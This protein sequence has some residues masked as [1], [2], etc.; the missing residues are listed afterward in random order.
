MSPIILLLLGFALLFVGGEVLVRAAVSLAFRIKI[1]TL[2]VGMTVVSFVTSAPELFVSLEALIKDSSNI[3][4]GNAIGS[5]IANITLVLGI[6]AVIFRVTISKQTLLLNYPM[7]LIASFALGLVLFFFK[8]IPVAFGFFFIA[9]LIIF[10]WILIVKSRR[11]NLRNYA[12]KQ[13]VIENT[14][15]DSLLKI[16]TFLILGVVSLKYGAD[17]LVD[18]AKDLATNFGVSD[19]IIAVTVLAIG[20]SIPELATSI[21]AAFKKE[22]NLLMGNLIGSNMFNILAVLGI[23]AAFKKIN[24]DDS[25]IFSFD[26]FWMLA[27][28]LALGLLIYIFSKQ[29]ISRKEGVFLILIYLFYMYQTIDKFI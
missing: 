13:I 25:A 15:D 29:K 18:A 24:I 3:A 12:H 27:V 23:T 10:V 28:T 2:V 19:R 26:Y 16:I 22:D 5:N 8:S 14:S 4:L 17:F 21:V 20:T 1:S 9:L 11:E 6:T 7:M